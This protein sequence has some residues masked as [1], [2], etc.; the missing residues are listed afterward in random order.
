MWS[1]EM[2]WIHANGKYLIYS[3]DC[4]ARYQNSVDD[5]Q[6]LYYASIR[7]IEKTFG[8]LSLLTFEKT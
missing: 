4:A 2:F 8:E 6:S 5:D 1:I 3:V 7:M